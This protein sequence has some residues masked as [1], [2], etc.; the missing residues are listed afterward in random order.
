MLCRPSSPG[1]E[2]LSLLSQEDE[3]EQILVAS[4]HQEVSDLTAI[5][6]ESIV[7]ETAEDSVLNCLIEQLQHGFPGTMKELQSSLHPF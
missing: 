1:S 4:T 7:S 5:S 3:K 2:Y 6:W